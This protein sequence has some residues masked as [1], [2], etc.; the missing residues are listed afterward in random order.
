M[1]S[2][3][4]LWLYSTFITQ[5]LFFYILVK[6]NQENHWPNYFYRLS[7]T[8][9]KHFSLDT[10][11]FSCSIPTYTWHLCFLTLFPFSPLLFPTTRFFFTILL[12][13]VF[14]IFF[15]SQE[16]EI[17]TALLRTCFHHFM[18]CWT[19]NFGYKICVRSKLILSL[20]WKKYT[21]LCFHYWANRLI[22]ILL[23]SRVQNILEFT[24]AKAFNC[25]ELQKYSDKIVS[26]MHFFSIQT[27]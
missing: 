17:N 16:C 18:E 7:S 11:A 14:H 6:E 9:K 22:C 8:M 4:F 13:Q 19:F 23:L 20:H 21:Y 26:S 10:L 25:S 27:L 1:H 2:C 15:I 24:V 12:L 5:L 3:E